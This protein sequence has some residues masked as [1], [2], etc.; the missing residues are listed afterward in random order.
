MNAFKNNKGS[1]VPAI[2]TFVLVSMK[3]MLA[4]STSVAILNYLHLLQAKGT[5]HCF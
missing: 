4:I 5:L 2:G 3:V 1:V